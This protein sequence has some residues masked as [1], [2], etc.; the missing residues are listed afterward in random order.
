VITIQAVSGVDNAF[1]NSLDPTIALPILFDG[2]FHAN[3][4]GSTQRLDLASIGIESFNLPPFPAPSSSTISGLGTLASPLHIQL[5][6]AANQAPASNNGFVKVHLYYK[7]VTNIV[8]EP[9][10]CALLL[11]GAVAI[12]GMISRVRHAQS[13]VF[14]ASAM[15]DRKLNVLV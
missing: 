13:D 12:I 3:N 2:F 11:A 8:P 7:T 10:T 6:L 9:S 1:V 15:I 5:G 4:L 14:E